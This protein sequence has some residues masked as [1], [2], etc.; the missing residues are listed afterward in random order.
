M[1]TYRVTALLLNVR[2]SPVSNTD[3]KSNVS[4][5]VKQGFEFDSINTVTNALGPWYQ[6]EKQLWYWGGGVAEVTISE[7]AE[8]PAVTAPVVK[9]A[10]PWWIS[11]YGIDSIWNT[12]KGENVKIAVLDS[13]YN[14]NVP[15]LADGVAAS[16]VFVNA[17]GVTINDTFGHGS[18]CASLAANRNAANVL[19]YAP[20][21]EL[22][23]AKISMDG[24]IDDFSVFTNAIQWAI[25]NRVDVI[26][27]S[28]GGESSD[29]GLQQAIT[30]AVNN[31]IVVVASIGDVVQYSTNKPCYPALYPNCIA[32]G[33]TNVQKQLSPITIVASKTEINAPGDAISGYWLSNT[34]QQETG[35]SQAAA[36][37]A[38]LCALMISR[39]R[40]LGINYSVN[41]IRELLVTHYQPIAGNATQ[42]LINPTAIFSNI[43][44]ASIT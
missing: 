27:I 10:Y 22:Y 43:T 13:G 38:G 14:V 16:Q 8:A 12:T 18:H 33:A 32:V 5:Q 2:T 30:D 6:D 37:V 3:D 1:A 17:T 11:D 19:G 31:N 4:T 15:D 34:P 41:D 25:S 42:K 24:S 20:E 9:T 23:I 21:A 28:Y 36:L 7:V 44:N 35:T 29:A 26:S 39:Y 40:S